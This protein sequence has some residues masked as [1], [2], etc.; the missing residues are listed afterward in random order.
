MSGPDQMEAAVPEA[1]SLP[2]VEPLPSLRWTRLA[3]AFMALG[4]GALW[5][6][7]GA[8]AFSWGA[9]G[10]W[11]VAGL[12]LAIPALLSALRKGFAEVLT[13]HRVVFL[14][15]FSMYFLFGAAL[16]AFG[17]E[18]QM[19]ASFSL[20]PSDPASVLRVDGINGLGFGV[21]LLMS[22]FT[23]GRLLERVAGKVADNAAR[24][25]Y[26]LVA[27]GFLAVGIGATAY[28]IPF[29]FGIRV[30]LVSGLVRN[31]GQLSLVAIF[32]AVSARGPHERLLRWMAVLFTVCLVMLGAVEFMKSEALLPMVALTAGLALRFGSRR[33]LPIGL[34]VIAS[35]FMVLGNLMNYGR[36]AVNSSSGPSTLSER[37][38]Y[39]KESWAGTR[40][41]DSTQQYPYW[42][43]LCYVPTQVA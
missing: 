31:L 22:G 27:G 5:Y 33:A 42:S 36:W 25:P 23:R 40:D 24:L 19:V 29:D 39:L 26:H 12:A 6:A 9:H 32:M 30:G 34:V 7:P 41:L 11:C 35:A 38:S 1:E 28:R 3:L 16:P 43:R 14:A 18:Q 15:A 13:D 8:D 17:P 4:A 21:A 2:T 10:A 37:W 20:Y